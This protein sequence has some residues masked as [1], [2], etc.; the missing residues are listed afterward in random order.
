MSK[1]AIINIELEIKKLKEKKK[2]LIAKREREVGA[3]L[4]KSWNISDKTDETIF[5]LID[6]NKPVNNTKNTDIKK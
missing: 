5:K 1:N 6:Q 3:Y 4:L 2:E